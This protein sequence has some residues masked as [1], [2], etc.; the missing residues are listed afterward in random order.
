LMVGADAFSSRGDS[1]MARAYFFTA[2]NSSS[3]SS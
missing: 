2:N 3:L 1:D